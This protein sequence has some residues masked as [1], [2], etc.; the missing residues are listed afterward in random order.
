MCETIAALCTLSFLTFVSCSQPVYLYT[1][2]DKDLS[3][4]SLVLHPR[5]AAPTGPPTAPV[6]VLAVTVLRPAGV[7]G[8]LAFVA[9]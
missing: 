6:V 7:G 1:I 5:L 4:S 8:R 2:Y 9:V 3:P